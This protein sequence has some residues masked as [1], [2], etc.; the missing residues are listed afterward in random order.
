MNKS[1][2]FFGIDISK[3]SFDVYGNLFGYKSYPNNKD[4]FKSFVKTLDANSYCVME[5]TGCYH[6]KLCMYLHDQGIGLS[7]LNPLIIK[8]F[9]QMKL[10]RIKTDKSDAYMIYN[11]ACEQPLEPWQPEAE[12][13][14]T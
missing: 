11:Y 12:Y 1:T 13:I 14:V 4:G 6:H 10:R 7:V 9:I 8:R 5:A 2:L 3:D